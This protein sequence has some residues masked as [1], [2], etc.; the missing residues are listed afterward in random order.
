MSVPLLEVEGLSKSYG[1]P[2]VLRRVALSLRAGEGLVLLGPNGAG[3]STLLRILAG[4]HRASGG[5]VRI[6]GEVARFREAPVRR[7]VGF[8]SHETFLYDALTARENLRF[9]AGL[10]G[11]DREG[12]IEEALRE[13]GLQRFA[14]RPVGR[15]SRGMAQRLTLARARLH[16]PSL[17]LLDEPFTG[18]DPNAARE[19]DAVLVAYRAKGGAFVMATHDLAHIEGVGTRLLVLRAGRIVHEEGLEG[20]GRAQLERIYALHAGVGI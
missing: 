17:L 11:I 8:V 20:L 19:L 2:P 3:K 10:Y 18:L 7:K 5:T 4:I 14:D 12:A 13:I 16:D 15:F 9:F 1:G 6:D